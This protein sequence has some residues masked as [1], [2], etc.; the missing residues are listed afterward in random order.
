M[1]RLI[2][3]VMVVVLCAVPAIMVQ[4]DD[5]EGSAGQTVKST[6]SGKMMSQSENVPLSKVDNPPVYM[7]AEVAV[8][9]LT[10]EVAAK[11]ASV[12][13][14]Y[15]EI[16][17]VKPDMEAGVVMVIYRDG[18]NFKADPWEKILMVK[19]DATLKGIVKTKPPMK[20][21]CGGCP[22]KAKCAGA[23]K[24]EVDAK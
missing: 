23:E 15:K 16:E 17:S 21:K 4:A 14:E 24:K 13:S 1:K 5:S 12:L 11:I 22:H 2:M 9:D 8:P 10:K 19:A 6:E 3:V 18:L 7:A 20:D